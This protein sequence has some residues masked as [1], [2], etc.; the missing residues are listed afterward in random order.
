MAENCNSASR[1][2]N[3]WCKRS[4]TVRRQLRQKET[5]L[6]GSAIYTWDLYTDEEIQKIG[7]RL[8]VD[9]NIPNRREA[10]QEKMKK[11]AIRIILY[12]C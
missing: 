1:I 9:K 8:G 11:I 5:I 3:P 6:S 2:F 12:G 7:N 10:I 4:K